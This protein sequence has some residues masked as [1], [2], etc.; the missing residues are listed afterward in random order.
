MIHP[1][2]CNGYNKTTMSEQVRHQNHNIIEFLKNELL[3]NR[4]SAVQVKQSD[5][6]VPGS[7]NQYVARILK[8]LVKKFGLPAV[9][10]SWEE[11]NIEAWLQVLRK[12]I[13]II[14]DESGKWN[15]INRD[16]PRDFQPELKRIYLTRYGG[17]ENLT[18]SMVKLVHDWFM[19][20]LLGA[21]AELSPP[22]NARRFIVPG[23]YFTGILG[24][25]YIL[26]KTRTF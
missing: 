10:K 20:R 26:N 6:Y 14:H 24:L 9:S 8:L 21:G 17:D 3:K 11:N 5:C 15:A 22:P 16:H 13:C 2:V 19:T 12:L 4:E 25:L 7:E 18:D 23:I 1:R